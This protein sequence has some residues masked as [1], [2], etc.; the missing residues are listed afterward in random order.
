MQCEPAQKAV[1]ICQVYDRQLRS[2]LARRT[3]CVP[4]PAEAVDDLMQQVTFTA[5]RRYDLARDQRPASTPALLFATA[6]SVAND[7]LKR[8]LAAKRGMHRVAGRPHACRVRNRRTA[9]SAPAWLTPLDYA[10]ALDLCLVV[11][12]AIERLPA[13]ERQV[14]VLCDLSAHTTADVAA[15]LNQSPRTI[16]ARR[17]R[18][19]ASLA[20]LLAPLADD[21]EER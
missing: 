1:E 11:R 5:W 13:D 17:S 9:A 12:E 16:C 4:D 10:C 19:R 3:A 20:V 21:L 2:F 15:V 6:G 14:V 7:A 8:R 18:A